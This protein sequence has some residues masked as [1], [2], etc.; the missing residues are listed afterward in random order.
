MVMATFLC[1]KCAENGTHSLAD[2]VLLA[3]EEALMGPAMGDPDFQPLAFLKWHMLCERHHAEL[4]ADAR[5]AYVPMEE[6]LN[7][8]I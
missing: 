6:T 3:D 8:V 1:D 2:Y 7:G 5:M 4:P